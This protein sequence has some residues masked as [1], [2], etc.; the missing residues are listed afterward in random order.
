MKHGDGDADQAVNVEFFQDAGVKH[1][2]GGWGGSVSGRGPGMEGK[3]ADE[4]AEADEQEEK[5]DVLRRGGDEVGGVSGV[6]G[7][8]RDVIL[9]RDDVERARPGR[10]GHDERDESGQ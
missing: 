9:E 10:Q 3:E 6:P 4:D 5:N 8:S 2:G 7:D 1:G